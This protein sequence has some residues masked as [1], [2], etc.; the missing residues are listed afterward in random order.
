MKVLFAIL[1]LLISVKTY[2]SNPTTRIIHALGVDDVQTEHNYSGFYVNAKRVQEYC[3]QGPRSAKV[4]CEIYLNSKIPTA[5]DDKKT[6]ID[7]MK[8]TK[9]IGPGSKKIILSRFENAIKNS[10]DG[11]Q[12]IL[13]LDGHGGTFG[14]KT[15]CIFVDEQSKEAP[16]CADDVEDIIEK[17]KKTNVKILIIAD[18]CRAGKFTNLSSKNVCILTAADINNW[19]YGIQFWVNAKNLK[20]PKTLKDYIDAQPFEERRLWG[21]GG[22]GSEAIS[23]SIC[24][25]NKSFNKNLKLM[26]YPEYIDS[27]IKSLTDEKESRELRLE[28]YACTTK[29]NLIVQVEYLNEN[30]RKITQKGSF[31]KFSELKDLYKILRCNNVNPAMA[32]SSLKYILDNEDKVKDL[33]HELSKYQDELNQIKSDALEAERNL[34]IAID[35]FDGSI[36]LFNSK[37]REAKKLAEAKQAE[38]RNRLLDKINEANEKLKNKNIGDDLKKMYSELQYVRDFMCLDRSDD[39]KKKTHV[40]VTSKDI[41]DTIE[42]FNEA[43]ECEKSFVLP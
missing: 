22:F 5:R 42:R 13:S 11:D 19:S 16:I 35:D 10:K 33:F 38:I 8:S 36:K 12:V 3:D 43:K 2:S 18:A 37:E 25:N 15:S 24:R 34:K 17:N 40:K 23:H 4:E 20:K 28:D 21:E 9:I 39:S 1:A 31:S 30:L 32:C 6:A 29:D 14:S 41:P 27:L 7:A 26:D